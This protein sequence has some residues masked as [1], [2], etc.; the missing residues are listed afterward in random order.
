MKWFTLAVLVLVSVGCASQKDVLDLQKEVATLK[1]AQRIDSDQEQTQKLHLEWAIRQANTGRLDCRA[2]A[3]TARNE[4]L[5]KNGTPD[6]AH[7]GWYTGN[8]DVFKELDEEEARADAD[9]QHEYED[10]VQSAKVLNA[11]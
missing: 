1:G 6:P 11:E 9:C 2:E 10:A 8:R 5:H 4:G 7:K 3:E